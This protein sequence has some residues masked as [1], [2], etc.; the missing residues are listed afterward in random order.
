MDSASVALRTAL[1]KSDYYY[2][3]I[4]RS[5]LL[6]FFQVLK[7]LPTWQFYSICEKMTQCHTHQASDK[8]FVDLL[9]VDLNLRIF[10]NYFLIITIIFII[11]G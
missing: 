4:K 1:Y 5:T 8:C 3:I 11:I 6:N 2:Y 9:H 10:K 7:N